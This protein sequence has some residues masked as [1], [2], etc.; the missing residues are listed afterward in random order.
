MK[1]LQELKRRF[2]ADPQCESV[3]KKAAPKAEQSKP[4]R[5]RRPKISKREMHRQLSQNIAIAMRDGNLRG[6]SSL[7]YSL[8]QRRFDLGLDFLDA[9]R[10]S[11]QCNL[12][13]MKQVG[14]KRVTVSTC[15]DEWCCSKCRALEGKTFTIKKALETM[16]LPVEHEA[17]HEP[18][19][20]TC[21]AKLL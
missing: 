19:R 14:V 3:A 7:Y 4:K 17:E 1:F 8:A 12:M 21:T 16:P 10:S 13:S 9:L 6:A 15:Q 5:R 20:C 18:C 2:T 11:H